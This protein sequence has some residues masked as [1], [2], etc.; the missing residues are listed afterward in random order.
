MSARHARI[1]PLCGCFGRKKKV[2]TSKR[3]VI[4]NTGMSHGLDLL[5]VL[6]GL[7]SATFA[8]KSFLAFTVPKKTGRSG[9]GSS[10]LVGEVLRGGG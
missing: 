6:C 2:V 10:G 7:S 5:S 9:G 8:V 3:R 1:L 4:E